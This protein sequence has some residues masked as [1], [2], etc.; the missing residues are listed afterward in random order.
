MFGGG[1]LTAQRTFIWAVSVYAGPVFVLQRDRY[2]DTT[3]SY[4]NGQY[5]GN[6]GE[7]WHTAAAKYSSG[8][9]SGVGNEG[10]VAIIWG[11]NLFSELPRTGPR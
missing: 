1:E 2:F 10:Q 3:P 5:E 7:C 9:F 11:R 6:D 4:G 8:T